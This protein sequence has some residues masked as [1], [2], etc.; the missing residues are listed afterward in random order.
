MASWKADII[1][2]R[3][4]T[5]TPSVKRSIRR[6]YGKSVTLDSIDGATLSVLK[7]ERLIMDFN[8]KGRRRVILNAWGVDF[9]LWLKETGQLKQDKKSGAQDGSLR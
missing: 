9:V 8:H 1:A 3:W 5:Y 4:S 2:A 6:M 7:Q